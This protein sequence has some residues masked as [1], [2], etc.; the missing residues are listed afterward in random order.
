MHGNAFELQRVEWRSVE[1]CPGGRSC[2][3]CSLPNSAIVARINIPGSIKKE[4]MRIGVQCRV[5]ANETCAS[6]SGF[7][8]AIRAWIWRWRKVPTRTSAKIYLAG[9]RRIDGDGNIVKALSGA[10]ST[11]A[12]QLSS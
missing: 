5:V 9:V 10:E 11:A 8:H 4:G 1:V 6:I 3:R 2:G 12:G 7:L